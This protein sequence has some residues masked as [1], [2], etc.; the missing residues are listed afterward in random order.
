MSIKPPLLNTISPVPPSL[1]FEEDIP[2]LIAS[3]LRCSLAAERCSLQYQYVLLIQKHL[4]SLGPTCCVLKA[5]SSPSQVK[6]N[7]YYRQDARCDD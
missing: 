1:W 6:P 5:A 4:S 7:D 2:F 3:S